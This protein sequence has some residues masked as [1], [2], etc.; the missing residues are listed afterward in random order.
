MIAAELEAH[1]HQG[2][3]AAIA[4]GTL[5]R[6]ELG[7]GIEPT[8]TRNIALANRLLGRRDEERRALEQIAR[9][10]PDSLAVLEAQG[11]I[12]VLLADTARA[13]RIDRILAEQSDRPLRAPMIRGL[14]IVARAHIAAGFGRREQAVTLLQDAK[15]R[16]ILYLGSSHAFHADPLLAPLRGYPPFD[17]LLQPDN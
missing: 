4:E 10:D 13:E 1:G 14:L 6:L 9:S 17:S 7:P 8:R 2:T 3:A 11:R 12:A 16:G 15:A 5:R